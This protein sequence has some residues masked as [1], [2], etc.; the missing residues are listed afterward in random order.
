MKTTIIGLLAFLYSISGLTQNNDQL[1]TIKAKV[2]AEKTEEALSY[3][4]I[5]NRQ[6]L[7]GTASNLEGYFELP[8]NRIGDTLVISYLGYMDRV[9]IVA[10]KMPA[11][12]S[13]RPNSA[14]LDEVVVTARNDYL[15]NLVAKARK[16]QRTQ[17][18]SAKTYFYLESF[19]S[20]E[21]IEIIE[22][23]Y[24][25][26][27]SNFGIDKLALKKG[28]IGLKPINRRYFKSTESSRLFS[29]H[30]IFTK[31][32]LFPDNPLCLKKGALKSQYRLKLDHIYFEGKSK[33]YVINFSPEEESAAL[34]S[35]TVWIDQNRKQVLK[36]NLKAEKAAVHPF[37]PIGFN[38]IDQVDMDITRSYTQINGQSFV[39]TIDFIYKVAYFDRHA[40][41]IE[42]TTKAFTKAYDYQNQFKLPHFQFTKHLHED[43]RNITAI[44]YDSLFWKG[45]TEFRFYDRM[46]EVEDFIL[47]NRV[48]SNIIAPEGKEDSLRSQLQFPYISWNSNRFGMREAPVK[49]IEESEEKYSFQKDRYHLSLKLYLDANKI[50]DSLIYQLHTILDPVDTY[51]HF[52]MSNT[53]L[54]FLNMYFDLLE[55]QKRKLEIELSKTKPLSL[56]IINQLYQ[57][58]MEIFEEESQQFIA[59]ANRG[60]N[61]YDIKAWNKYIF[62]NLGVNNVEFF[63][64]LEENVSTK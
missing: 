51:Y 42:A 52:Y 31:S 16:N 53:D 9:M 37:L 28:R 32:E 23:Y 40:N 54:A 8:N 43:Y 33:I 30:D 2:V 47:T 25:G 59:E 57:K 49:T 27:Y 63:Q 36:I 35:G 13:L 39:N 50:N 14:I 61:K 17:S 5:F 10:S 6:R 29:M 44:P 48:K 26:Q 45:S 62:E 41:K 60:Q 56:E 12:I 1:Y 7:I 19:I 15:Y 3:A 21:P 58:H 22:S 38:N 64:S 4:N 20:D 24:N 18:K 55:I 11:E 46:Q 34:F